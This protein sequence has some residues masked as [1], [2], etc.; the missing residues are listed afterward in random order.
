M[1]HIST[2]KEYDK[3]VKL[4]SLIV[5]VIS[6][7]RKFIDLNLII[8][9]SI[10]NFKLR[11]SIKIWFCTDLFLK[12]AKATKLFAWSQGECKLMLIDTS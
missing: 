3:S 4:C 12:E 10:S 8:S 7:S 9:I 11:N 5:D 1:K 2:W 6:F